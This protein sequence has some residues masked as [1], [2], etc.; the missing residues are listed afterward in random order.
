MGD[1]SARRSVK[2]P[3]HLDPD[4]EPFDAAA[5]AALGAAHIT[6][7]K[8]TVPGETQSPFVTSGMRIGT[9]A[10][11]TRGMKEGEMRIIA[12]MIDRVLRA[13]ADESVLREV[14][15]EARQLAGGFPL[16]PAAAEVAA[17]L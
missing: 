16:Y 15:A 12:G 4:A 10:V 11:T 14:G 17:R 9:S 8:N 2:G 5:E 6:V 13:P 7:N 1:G 3:G